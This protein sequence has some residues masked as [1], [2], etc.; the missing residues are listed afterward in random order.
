MKLPVILLLGSLLVVAATTNVII[1][2][3]EL[4]RAKITA[5]V[6]NESG[7]PMPGVDV[8]FSFAKPFDANA[9]V[10]EAGL[11]DTQGEF[12]AEGFSDGMFGNRVMKTG[13]YES[14]V[15]LPKFLNIT[16]G[17]WQP[18][19]PT[20]VTVL[21]PIGKPVALCAKRVE[22]HVPL[23][24]KP[25]GYDLEKGDWVAPNG[26]GVVSD[27]IFSAHAEVRGD[28]DFDSTAQLTFPNSRDGL[29]QTLMPMVATNSV[30][31]WERQ[32]PEDGFVP[33]LAIRNAWF[34]QASGKRPIRTF[35]GQ[36]EWEGYFFRVRTVEE[37]GKIVSALY[38]KI[39]G[40]IAIDPRDSKTC[41]ILFTYYLNTT[42]L[43]RNLEWDTRHNLL[44]GLKGMEIPNKP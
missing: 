36:N 25:C 17:H 41:A 4:P 1:Q 39:L 9:V 35:K 6:I 19:N 18:W 33:N 43:D 38:G 22:T 15:P 5:R 31:K 12:T 8:R 16:N 20:A 32:A 23:L 21:R 34:P 37:N 13:Y 24:D 7:E 2:R 11:T 30:F 10:R 28:L 14:C 42:P 26:K 27:F 29:Q 40:G 44:T 3:H